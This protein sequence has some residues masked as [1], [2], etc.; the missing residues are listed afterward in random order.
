MPWTT[1]TRRARLPAD[2]EQLRTATERRARGM[3]E[4]YWTPG[5]G[6]RY[7]QHHP[8]CDGIGREADHIEESD[9]HSLANLQ[10]LST[11]CHKVKTLEHATAAR[12]AILAAARRAPERHPLAD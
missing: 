2:W 1:S 6:G 10:W 7:G 8:D 5:R 12:R 4:A 3:C 11:P 9:D